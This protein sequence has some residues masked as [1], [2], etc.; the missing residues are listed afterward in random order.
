MTDN[1][2]VE[3]FRNILRNAISTKGIDE[4]EVDEDEVDEII[5]EIIDEA[6]IQLGMTPETIIEQARQG[7]A[8]GIDINQQ[9]DI[10]SK[11]IMKVKNGI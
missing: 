11:I 2:I 1:E 10:L 3:K 9:M 7:E 4:D 6:Y 5:D 8:N